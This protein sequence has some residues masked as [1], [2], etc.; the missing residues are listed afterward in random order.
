MATTGSGRF[1]VWSVWSA[2]L[3]MTAVNILWCFGGL[4]V[5]S[6]E[7]SLESSPISQLLA[8]SRFQNPKHFREV[9]TFDKSSALLLL[10]T[11]PYLVIINN[12]SSR[13]LTWYHAYHAYTHHTHRTYRT[14]YIWRSRGPPVWGDRA[15]TQSIPLQVCL[16]SV[17]V[18]RLPIRLPAKSALTW[19][20]V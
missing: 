9:A 3:C 12:V 5:S 13:R 19:P 8:L 4:S 6:Y 17:T 2:S 18:Y 10:R 11:P 20:V 16:L 15:E 1:R 14:W 7:H